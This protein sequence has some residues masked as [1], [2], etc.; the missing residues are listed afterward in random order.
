VR[1]LHLEDD[2]NDAE[3]IRRAITDE[4]PGST[5]VLCP[6]REAYQAQLS[7]LDCD[8]ILSDYTLTS[9]NG[10][11]ALTLAR[12]VDADVP[13]IF[14]SGTIGEDRALA[15]LQLG[16]DDYVLKD[17]TKRLVTAIRRVLRERTDRRQR[18]EAERKN[19]VQIDLL[20]RVR[21]A[22]IVTN[23][24]NRVIFW[25][26]GAERLLGP[27][28]AESLGQVGDDLFGPSVVQRL[29]AGRKSANETGEWMGEID[30][31]TRLGAMHHLE[32]RLS[33]I[34]DDAGR[35]RGHFAI[36][37]DVTEKK[38]LEEQL[39][40]AQRVD[41]I[42]LLAAGIAHDLNNILSPIL[43]AA[44]MLRERTADPTDLRLLNMLEKS[45]ER[46][47][48]LVRQILSFAHG[49]SGER[50]VLAIKHVVREI[51]GVVAETFPKNIRFLTRIAP[52]LHAIEANPT[53]IHQVLLNLCLNA[54][55]A[56]PSGGEL[57]IAAE[58]VTL[59]EAAACEIDGGRAGPH[60]LVRVADNGTGISPEVLAEMWRPFYTTKEVGKGT[61]LGLS[62]VRGI[63]ES[64]GGFSAVESAVGEG[65]TFRIYFPTSPSEREVSTPPPAAPFRRGHG[66]LIL[67]V[68]DE[69][70]VRDLTAALLVRA[71][72]RVLTASDGAEAFNLFVQRCHEISLVISDTRMPRLNGR[73]LA[74]GLRRIYPT[75]KILAMSGLSQADDADGATVNFEEYAAGFLRKP[76]KPDSLLSTV[77]GLIEAKG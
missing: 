4:W 1:V 57:T 12:E 11:E 60:I 27:T 66:E 10:L 25:N 36:C 64:H 26:R 51:A 8:L 21:D 2:P 47:A 19:Q 42:G 41:N 16:A 46:G 62:T 63:V 50:R 23:E 55:D 38:R 20:N 76:F 24:E 7:R 65:T 48:G 29:A 53:Q 34:S 58:N 74:H 75:V 52:D 59:S 9:F 6:D 70:H 3:L 45:A 5:I 35:A 18:L 69:Q 73:Q 31:S 39:L 71:G 15:A 37:T 72:Y 44:P 61:G 54:R 33:V 67:L 28:S 40:R 17:R 13:F 30:V 32:V 56:M 68:D 49:V 14:L 77:Q 43:M 22:I